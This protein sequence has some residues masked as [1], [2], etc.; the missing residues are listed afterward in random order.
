MVHKRKIRQQA[1]RDTPLD[2]LDTIKLSFHAL[3][4][5]P[6]ALDAASHSGYRYR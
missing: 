6:I 1:I 3:S 5:G 4:R 2:E